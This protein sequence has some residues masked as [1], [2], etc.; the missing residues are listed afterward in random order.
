MLKQ[1]RGVIRSAPKAEEVISY[2][3]CC[4]KYHGML[5]AFGVYKDGCSLYSIS[6]TLLNEI[7]D[8]KGATISGKTLHLSP[9]KPLP[10]SLIKKIVKA[11]LKENELRFK[12]KK[13]K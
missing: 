9:T 11:R 1:I 8:L 3:V 10:K 6:M 7:K 2:G 13:K 12:N 4:Y 5:I